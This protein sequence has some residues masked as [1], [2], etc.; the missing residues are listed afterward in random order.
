M[1]TKSGTVALNLKCKDSKIKNGAV[2][3]ATCV[4]E[5]SL[6]ANRFGFSGEKTDRS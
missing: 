3:I 6:Q 1:Q 4:F 2:Q 5:Y